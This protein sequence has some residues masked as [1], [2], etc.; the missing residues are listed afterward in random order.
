MPNRTT[1]NEREK[2]DHSS[3]PTD[4]AT[5]DDLQAPG[6]DATKPK[7]TGDDKRQTETQDPSGKT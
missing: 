5:K 3:H 7:K 2:V 1:F 6:G 4:R